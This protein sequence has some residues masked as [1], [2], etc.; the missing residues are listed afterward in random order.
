MAALALILL[1]RGALTFLFSTDRISDGNVIR[2][3]E[4]LLSHPAVLAVELCFIVLTVRHIR[5]KCRH[6]SPMAKTAAIASALIL[7][8]AGTAFLTGMDYPQGHGQ[9]EL[10]M[11][12]FSQLF[13]ITLAM[14]LIM[15]SAVYIIDYALAT[16]AA[17]Y[18][19]RSKASQARFQYA[20]LKQQV[21]PHFLFNSLN[22]LDCMVQEGQTEQA[23]AFIHKLAGIYR[24]MLRNDEKT[25]LL[26]D[27][28]KFV[29]M[30]VDLLKERF[31]DGFKVI[32]E[33]P[34]DIGRQK[35]VIPCSV[36]MLIENAIKHNQVGGK[37][38]LVI[39]I[40]TDGEALTVTN[41]LRPK[42]NGSESTKV[43]LNYLREQY[44]YLYGKN[45]ETYSD[46]TQYR[47][48]IPLTE[49]QDVRRVRE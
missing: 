38:P 13:V 1:F 26:Q 3:T 16:R 10:S 31:S 5:L 21:N 30:Y 46:N 22:I 37:E 33:I 47:V 20:K 23:S 19:E 36:Q 9:E 44:R 17:M 49:N 15:Y 6:W 42:L 2:M 32:T 27:E 7:M 39:R 43:G 25:V 12:R 35:L 28:M 8:A 11:H 34:E 41:N 29:G 48:S 45:V 40:T 18:E 24:Y 14:D 4:T